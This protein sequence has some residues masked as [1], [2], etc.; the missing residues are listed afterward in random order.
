MVDVG[1]KFSAAGQALPF[2][3]HTVRHRL[4]AT[5]ANLCWAWLPTDSYHMAIFGGANNQQRQPGLSPA[6]V[7]PHASQQQ[8]DAVCASRLRGLTAAPG[9]LR[10]QVQGFYD[11]GRCA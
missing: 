11:R 7:S 1:V 2:R 4:Q 6:G 10:L 5:S 9:P 3:G 8:C